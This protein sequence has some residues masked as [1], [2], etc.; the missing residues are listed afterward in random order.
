M[1]AWLAADRV[2]GGQRDPETGHHQD[3]HTEDQEAGPGPGTPPRHLL[4]WVTLIT[5]DNPKLMSPSNDLVPSFLSAQA[6][7]NRGVNLDPLGKWS[8]VGLII[9]D[10]SVPIG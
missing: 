7:I 6:L 3:Q 2:P 4:S 5:H 8:K 9:F 1:C 10:S